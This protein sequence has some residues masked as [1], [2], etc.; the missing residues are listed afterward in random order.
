MQPSLPWSESQLHSGRWFA[1][2][3]T[4]T[5]ADAICLLEFVDRRML[6]TQLS[7]LRSRLGAHMVPG[8]TPLLDRLRNELAEY[9]AGTRTTF[10]VPLTM[11]GTEFQQSVWDSLMEIPSGETCSYSG[12]AAKLGR[13]DAARAVAKANGD[14]RIAII[15]PCHRVIGKGWKA[16]GLR[17]W[18]VAKAETFRPRAR[19]CHGGYPKAVMTV[20]SLQ[21]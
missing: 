4:G 5:A 21:S 11:P 16:N 17:R 19:S 12:L 20:R 1:G 14:N 13:P 10:D 3:T 8:R 15:I 9:W 6:E 2:A 18:F 7:R